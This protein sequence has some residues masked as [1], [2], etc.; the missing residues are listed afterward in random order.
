M[1]LRIRH[2][3]WFYPF[4]SKEMKESKQEEFPPSDNYE[5]DCAG[6]WREPPQLRMR[7]AFQSFH[8]SSCVNEHII[9]ESLIDE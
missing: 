6:N 9:A 5:E 4:I 7:N 8:L 1:E 2:K 3:K